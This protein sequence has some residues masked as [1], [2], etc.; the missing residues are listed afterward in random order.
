MSLTLN[1]NL[2]SKD[3]ILFQQEHAQIIL[4][5]IEKKTFS[6][7]K[8]YPVKV[9]NEDYK[10]DPEL[11]SVIYAVRGKVK[12]DMNL[13][14]NALKDFK[15]S[16]QFYDQSIILKP[17][18]NFL[19]FNRAYVKYDCGEFEESLQDV[20]QALKLKFKDNEKED[21]LSALSLRADLYRVCGFYKQALE[22]YDAVI[23]EDPNFPYIFSKRGIVHAVLGNLNQALSDTKKGITETHLSLLGRHAVVLALL[24]DQ[25][26]AKQHLSKLN[27]VPPEQ[28][29]YFLFFQGWVNLISSNYDE[30]IKNFTQLLNLQL[31]YSQYYLGIF[32]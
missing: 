26:G 17:K 7:I 27:P 5:K 14:E 28:L 16:I 25:T 6:P 1:N 32:F 29:H 24:K 12:D 2:T 20:N 10:E 4:S 9:L 21:K 18:S 3:L 23:K 15:K 13:F 30:A 31:A 8:F 22:D 19:F 11:L